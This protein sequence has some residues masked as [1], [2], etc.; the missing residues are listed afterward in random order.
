M[1]M[2]SNRDL[3]ATHSA[4]VTAL[5][6]LE[7][8][9]RDAGHHAGSRAQD[10]SADLHHAGLVRG[11]HPV[12]STGVMLHLVAQSECGAIAEI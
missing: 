7:H 3:P 11:G 10:I 8:S 5:S 6:C 12:G 2:R 4:A 1:N 9:R